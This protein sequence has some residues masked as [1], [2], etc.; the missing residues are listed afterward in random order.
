MNTVDFVDHMAFSK[1]IN[2]FHCDEKV[3]T[4]SV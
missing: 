2:L 3:A 1:L 4:D